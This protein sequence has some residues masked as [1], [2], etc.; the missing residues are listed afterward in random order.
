MERTGV[1][2][3]MTDPAQL[4]AAAE[5]PE[6]GIEEV[7]AS[8]APTVCQLYKEIWADGGGRSGWSAGQWEKELSPKEIRTWVANVADRPVGFAEVGWQRNGHVVIVVIGVIP[9]FQG[10]GIGGDFVSRITALAWRPPTTRVWLWTVPDE[11]PHTV[12]NYLSRGFRVTDRGN[13]AD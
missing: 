2:L 12:P 9:E 3:E 5:I 11:H 13:E 6:L 4:R 7:D 10:R 1:N 8:A